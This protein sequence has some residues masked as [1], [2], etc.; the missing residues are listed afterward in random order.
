MPFG[1]LPV[2]NQTVAIDLVPLEQRPK[3][4]L[5][6]ASFYNTGGNLY[7]YLELAVLGWKC[8]GRWSS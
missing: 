4:P 2:L 5:G 3:R 1:K 8:G 6:K 7:R